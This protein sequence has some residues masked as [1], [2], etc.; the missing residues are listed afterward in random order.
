M[1]GRRFAPPPAF[2]PDISDEEKRR[3]AASMKQTEEEEAARRDKENNEAAAMEVDMLAMT[4]PSLGSS[5]GPGG[6][7]EPGHNSEPGMAI[8]ELEKV[9]RRVH[10]HSTPGLLITGSAERLL[11][12]TRVT[13]FCDISCS[14]NGV[15]KEFME[16]AAKLFSTY[17]GPNNRNK[18]RI[19]A[20][21]RNR[22]DLAHKLQLLVE[23]NLPKNWTSMV[24]QLRKRA[25]QSSRV[26]PS[27]AML[28]C[29]LEDLQDEQTCVEVVAPSRSKEVRSQGLLLR[30]TEADCPLRV[31]AERQGVK[32]TIGAGAHP[33]LYMEIRQTTASVTCS[34]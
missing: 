23:E 5:G 21:V 24:I 28:L 4:S 1:L 25:T 18:F 17:K 19:V 20:L 13:V 15:A 22:M 34:V 7:A 14:S 10:F 9:M 32:D 33:D 26:K 6:T 2:V 30:C 3:V 31:A 16:T 29:P 27:F 8:D 11:E 12:S